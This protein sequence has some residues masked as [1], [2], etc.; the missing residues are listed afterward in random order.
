MLL[1]L[2]LEVRTF[3]LT[4]RAL[5]SYA[6]GCVFKPPCHQKCLAYAQYLGGSRMFPDDLWG[7][8]RL[9]VQISKP[10]GLDLPKNQKHACDM[11]QYHAVVMI[12]LQ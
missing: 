6:R 2:G 7:S 3:S 9:G 11:L 12:L 4:V 10:F 5:G 8:T 1:A